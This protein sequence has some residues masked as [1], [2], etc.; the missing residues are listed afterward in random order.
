MRS[1]GLDDADH[2]RP[3]HEHA[4]GAVVLDEP[5]FDHD[6]CPDPG[7]GPMIRQERRWHVLV[8]ELP[9]T[10]VPFVSLGYRSHLAKV[11][12]ERLAQARVTPLLGDDPGSLLPWR[13]VTH[14]LR[15]PALEVGDPV[16]LRVLVVANDVSL[17][18]VAPFWCAE[19]D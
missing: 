18:G 17:Q 12:I 15:M 19:S 10:R 16:A 7:L 4:A 8:G 1:V 11:A 14:V 6:V 5:L 3:Q 13:C 9:C 2:P